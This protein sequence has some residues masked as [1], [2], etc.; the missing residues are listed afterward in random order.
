MSLNPLVFNGEHVLI[1]DQLPEVF[2][3]RLPADKPQSAAK[4][5]TPVQQVPDSGALL[6]KLPL[7]K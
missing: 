2:L 5:Q 4:P 6:Q 1:S 7:S 3:H